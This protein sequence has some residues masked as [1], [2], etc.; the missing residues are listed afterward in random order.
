MPGPAPTPTKPMAAH[1][2]PP[3]ASFGTI[4]Y[5]DLPAAL[6]APDPT[7]T[8]GPVVV[9]VP[10][11]PEVAPVPAPMAPGVYTNGVLTANVVDGAIVALVDPTP[12][13]ET[14]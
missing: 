8:V 1:D 4:P 11:V 2:G 9:D 10:L 5:G 14:L 6:V 7:P 13:V 3:D 12:T